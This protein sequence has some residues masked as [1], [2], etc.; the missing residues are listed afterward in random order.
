MPEYA[1]GFDGANGNILPKNTQPLTEK[2][3]TNALV[4][5]TVGAAAGGATAA[6]IAQRVHPQNVNQEAK[7]LLTARTIINRNSTAA[8]VTA[9]KS[10]F[11]KKKP[12]FAFVRDRSGNGGGSFTR[13]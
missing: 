8:D 4:A 3:A 7:P 13:T 5:S 10:K 2:L 9:L 11:T 12:S 1:P 6:T